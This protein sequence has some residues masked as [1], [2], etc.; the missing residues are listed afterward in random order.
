MDNEWEMGVSP[1]GEI[2]SSKLCKTD[3][4]QELWLWAVMD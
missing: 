4:D 1:Q 3:N 2:S